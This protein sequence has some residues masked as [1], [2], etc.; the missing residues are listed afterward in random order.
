ML[1]KY[2]RRRLILPSNFNLHVPRKVIEG[3]FSIVIANLEYVISANWWGAVNLSTV[4]V[5]ISVIVPVEPS[6]SI[7]S[8]ERIRVDAVVNYLSA[9]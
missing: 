9:D 2:D 5:K 1:L 8:S 3:H 6:V 7:Y 4:L